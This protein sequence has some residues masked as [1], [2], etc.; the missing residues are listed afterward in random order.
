MLSEFLIEEG[1]VLN[2]YDSCVANKTLPS[3]KQLTICWYVDDLKISSINEDTVMAT[4]DKLEKCF[5][6][7]RK[8]FGKK[9][10]Y[11]GTEFEFCDG[12][13]VKCTMPDHIQDAIDDFG[14]N[15][16]R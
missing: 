1:F 8:S 9:H 16:G 5:G 14:E 7:M 11:L 10:S 2:L 15:L 3:G 13:S 4:I 6:V 12:G